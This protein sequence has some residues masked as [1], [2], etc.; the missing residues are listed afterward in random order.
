MIDFLVSSVLS[1]I[2]NSLIREAI[3]SVDKGDKKKLKK[4]ILELEN[5]ISQLENYVVQK[6]YEIKKLR[7]RE[8]F[9]W[10][11]LFLLFISLIFFYYKGYLILPF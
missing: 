1:G 5:Y 9:Y 7:R 11:F 8:K 6:E 2:A 10:F 4:Y 3:S